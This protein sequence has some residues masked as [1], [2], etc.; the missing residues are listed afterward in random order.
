MHQSVH[1]QQQTKP[2]LSKLM[3]Y[4]VLSLAAVISRVRRQIKGKKLSHLST[5]LSQSRQTGFHQQRCLA[6]S[7]ERGSHS[8]KQPR[9]LENERAS[10]R[11]ASRRPQAMLGVTV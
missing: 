4:S 10:E 2:W 5:G 9:Y 8:E 3:L 7:E 6:G 1:W 11:L